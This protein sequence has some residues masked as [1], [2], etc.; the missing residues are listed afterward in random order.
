MIKFYYNGFK[1]DGKLFK[2]YI[3]YGVN[4][5]GKKV[6]T[7]YVKGYGKLPEKVK[8]EFKIKNGTDITTDYFEEDHFNIEPGD[9]YFLDALSAYVIDRK[10]RILTLEKRIDNPKTKPYLIEGFKTDIDWINRQIKE[11]NETYFKEAA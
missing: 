5:Y 2:A 9:K 4:I 3:S 6:I 1:V 7:V 11:I 8:S 10:K